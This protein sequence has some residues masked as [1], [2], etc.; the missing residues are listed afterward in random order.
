MEKIK[1]II[2]RAFRNV[3]YPES[4]D[5]S[6]AIADFD[7]L[8][9]PS[10]GAYEWQKVDAS[11]LKAYGEIIHFFEIHAAI[12]YLQSYLIAL[13]DDYELYEMACFDSLV[14]YLDKADVD[15]FDDDQ[16]FAI[17]LFLDYCAKSV[18]PSIG[19]D[20]EEMMPVLIKKFRTKD[21]IKEGK[22]ILSDCLNRKFSGADSN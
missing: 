6:H 16:I 8:D 7:Y 11:V 12:Y 5:M 20:D 10:S 17:S 13:L 9:R 4:Y 1:K 14:S 3:D 2:N 21:R 18:L 22:L 15:I 19:L